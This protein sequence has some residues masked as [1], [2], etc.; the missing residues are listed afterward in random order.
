M[1]ILVNNKELEAMLDPEKQ[2]PVYWNNNEWLS[3]Q[4]K[5]VDFEDQSMFYSDK[6]IK[7]LNT[8]ATKRRQK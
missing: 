7:Y 5:R 2:N 6:A 4:A 1:H 3:F 8:C